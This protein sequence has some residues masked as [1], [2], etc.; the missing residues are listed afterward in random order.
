MGHIRLLFCFR[1]CLSDIQQSLV[2]ITQRRLAGISP[3]QQRGATAK[4]I[5]KRLLQWVI[6]EG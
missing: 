3:E 1:C 2:G 4:G 6:D 5:E